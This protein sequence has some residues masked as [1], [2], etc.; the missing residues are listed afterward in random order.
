M[1]NIRNIYQ[2]FNLPDNT[3]TIYGL[4]AAK[5]ALN[6]DK[7]EIFLL[8]TTNKNLSYWKEYV[9]KLEINIK[10]LTL[11]NKELNLLSNYNSHQ[12]VII[13]A[14]KLKRITLNEY[15][16]KCKKN[17]QR[18]LI[19]DQLTDPQNVGSVI[20]S[21]YA[22]NF[23]AV[24][25]LKKNSPSE[26]SSLVKASAGEIEKIK[27]IEL[28]NLTQEIQK[29][30]KFGFY[31]YSLSNEGNM[32]IKN[33]DNSD[34]KIALIIGSEGKG[35]RNLTKKHSDYIFKIPINGNCNSLNVANA[36][37]IALYTL[38]K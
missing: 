26:T 34:K 20:R 29:L 12:N 14:K 8:I 27:I 2:E 21:A 11:E 17:F 35:I 23:D 16:S 13:F 1:K 24:C 7:R 38:G 18:I 32:S 31:I 28:G 19:L 4:H 6:N 22:F 3:I 5:S 30:R 25:I 9:K 10:I 15:L 37:A 33:I 36:T